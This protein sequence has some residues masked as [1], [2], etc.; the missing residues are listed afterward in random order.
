[1]MA[2][3]SGKVALVTGATGCDISESVR[4]LEAGKVVAINVEN[5]GRV[6]VED[7]LL[8]LD[9][10]ETSADREA[11]ARDLEAAS[12]EAARRKV[13]V[14]AAVTNALEA[15]QLAFPLG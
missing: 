5:G 10:T 9:P 1:M 8:E 7:V 12:A 13:A 6:A 3:S 4:R 11:Q 14:A 15:P 2:Q